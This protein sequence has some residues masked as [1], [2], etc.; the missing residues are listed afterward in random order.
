MFV[1]G[2]GL[3]TGL[4]F[5]LIAWL[6]APINIES[7]VSPADLLNA[8]RRHVVF[9]LLAWGPVFG[10]VAGLINMFTS[11]S[12]FGLTAGLQSAFYS[13]RRS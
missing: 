2:V 13:S 8:D 9:S 4:I 11:G 6:E 1:P 10:L 3:G 5:G 12:G 7:A